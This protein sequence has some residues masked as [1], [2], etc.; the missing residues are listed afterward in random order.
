MG[1]RKELTCGRSGHLLI[2][3]VSRIE[4][5]AGCGH[6][7]TWV[8][9]TGRIAS[10]FLFPF[11]VKTTVLAEASIRG[12]DGVIRHWMPLVPIRQE[13]LNTL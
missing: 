4:M 2:K 9:R 7:W 10:A 3:E 1:L 5:V 12:H 13:S 11:I 8:T 6:P